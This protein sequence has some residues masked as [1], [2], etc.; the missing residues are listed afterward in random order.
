[1]RFLMY[2]LGCAVICAAADWPR[3]RGPNGEGISGEQGLPIELGKDKNVVWKAQT[4]TGNSSPIVLGKR[5]YF[6][7][8]EGDDL[9]TL[10]LDA[11]RGS[12]VWKKTIKRERN[13]APHPR[14]GATTPTPATDGRNL[15]I[16][17]PDFGLLA[18]D[19][20]GTEL[21]RVPLG[22]FGAVQGMAVSPVYAEGKVILLVDTPEEAFVTAYDA[23]SG[24]PVWKAERPIGF[25][26]SYATPSIYKPANGP[27]QLIVAGAVELTSYQIK[28]GERLW[29]ARGV[30]NAPAALPLV[31]GDAVYTVEPS[32]GGAPPFSQMLSQ[33]DKDKNGTIELTEVSGDAI[34]E[35][36]MFRLFKAIDKH[37]GDGNSSLTEAEYEKSFNPDSPGGGLVRTR[38]N[39]KNDVSKTHI[40][41]RHT[42]GL[43]YVTAPLL[44]KGILYVVRDGG[45]LATFDPATGKLLREERLKE[46]LGPYYASPVAADG[47]IWFVNLEGKVSVVRAGA[48][49]EVI[50]SAD[51]GEQ[52]IATPAIS[53]GCL[54]L[55]TDKS[56][57]CFGSKPAA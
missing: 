48:D 51:L 25:L 56:L 29:W 32:G 45:I 40:E 2:V 9:S 6:T 5:I 12:V 15:F 21:W 52:V 26:G 55:R 24:K 37:I 38:L 16:Y 54:Y 49:W 10:C 41:W 11:D 43:P 47:K 23:K 13:Q 8:Y 46:A 42:K 22:S 27:A 17:Y 36:I 33:H 34:V 53:N 19:R 50:A 18:Y 44:Y 4:P 30:T 57:Y 1:M 28:T 31:A 20:D 39:G 35:K 14:N 7:G 3:Y